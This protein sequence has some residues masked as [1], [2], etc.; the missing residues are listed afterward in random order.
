MDTGSG[1]GTDPGGAG[2]SPG[3]TCG[4]GTGQTLEG[5][6]RGRQAGDG[7]GERLGWDPPD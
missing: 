6:W 5:D 4:G 3:P 2:S 1:R 7:T